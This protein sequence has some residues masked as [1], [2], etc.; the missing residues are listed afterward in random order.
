M[1]HAVMLHINGLRLWYGEIHLHKYFSYRKF[2]LVYYSS[3][4]QLYSLN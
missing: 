1:L 3:S 2:I 4:L